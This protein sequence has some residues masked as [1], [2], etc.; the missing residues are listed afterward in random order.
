M[1]RHRLGFSP[2][3]KSKT[4]LPWTL[5]AI[6]GL[7]LAIPSILGGR[8]AQALSEDAV[9]GSAPTL[10]PYVIAGAFL[11][12]SGLLSFLPR[13]LKT[14]QVGNRSSAA[15]QLIEVR[16]LGAKQSLVLTKVGD[17]LL[18]VGASDQGLST[19]S[20][21]SVE[22]SAAVMESVAASPQSPFRQVLN[23]VEQGY[24]R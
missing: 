7:L 8:E 1:G 20:E 13:L 19:L 5:I 4:L 14:W 17:R 24:A 16:R 22:E 12:I 9:L 21:F 2:W 10:D 6:G 18:L 11:V 15:I 3:S 23:Q